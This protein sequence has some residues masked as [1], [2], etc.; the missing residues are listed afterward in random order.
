MKVNLTLATAAL[1]L[2]ACGTSVQISTYQSS[3]KNNLMSNNDTDFSPVKRTILTSGRSV[4]VELLTIDNGNLKIV[5]IPTRG[6]GIYEVK[7]GDIRLGWDS[8]LEEI[9]HPRLINLESRNGLGWLEGFNEWMVRCGLEFAG[10]PGTDTWP[11]ADGGEASMDLSLHGKVQNIPATDVEW[12]VL[13]TNPK[14]IVVRGTVYEKFFYGPK[15]KMV[16]EVRTEM[17]SDKFTIKDTVTN[18]GGSEQEFSLIYHGNYGSSILEEGAK[19]S[20]AVKKVSPLND[21]AGQA[22]NDWQVY[23]GPTQGF[24]EEVFCIEPKGDESGRTL[25]VLQNKAG[26]VATSVSWNVKELPYLNLWKNTAS[27]ADGYVTGIEPATGY[28]YNRKVE[29]ATGRLPKLQPN[30]TREFSLE[31]G[32]HEGE[33]AVQGVLQEVAAIQGDTP[34]ELTTETPDGQN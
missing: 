23:Q 25:A 17:G 24:V 22:I 18:L 3:R 11:T 34:P 14:T 16:S 31:F 15:L 30:Q 27:K 33:G 20:A 2:G 28:A 8:P 32:I 19:V 1:L 9:V 12:E 29:R 21:H 26:D 5:V 7:K 4:G 13:D 6:M 10:H